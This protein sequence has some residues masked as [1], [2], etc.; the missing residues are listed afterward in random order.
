MRV[1]VEQLQSSDGQRWKDDEGVFLGLSGPSLLWD[2][3]TRS[4]GPI[5]CRTCT[6]FYVIQRSHR[7]FTVQK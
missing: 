5:S 6:R 3:S 4:H 1:V 2:V 7:V